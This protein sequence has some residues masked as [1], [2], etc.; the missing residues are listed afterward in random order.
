MTAPR[1]C[2]SALF[3]TRSPSARSGPCAS[4]RGPRTRSSSAASPSSTDTRAR[5]ATSACASTG[6]PCPRRRG[7]RRGG[8]STWISGSWHGASC[9]PHSTPRRGSAHRTRA[10]AGGHSPSWTAAISTPRSPRA[11]RRH[12]P[13]STRARVGRWEFDLGRVEAGREQEARSGGASVEL[14][15]PGKTWVHGRVVDTGTGQPTPV[16]L[17]FRSRE[18]RY[19]PP[20]GH[21]TEINDGWFQDYGADVKL[22]DTPFAYVD[23]TFQVEL[24]VGEVYVE[25]TKGFE[26][27]P[28]RR[29]L[30][31]E[32][33]QRE[34]EIG[35]A[36][37]TDLRSRRLGHG[38]H[39]RPLPV[40]VDRRPRGSGR[41]RQP[42]QPAGRAVGRSLHERGRPRA[43]CARVARR[44]DDR[45]GEHREP[46]APAR[47][48]GPRRR[49]GRTGLSHVGQRAR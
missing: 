16:R 22:M 32:A 27:A 28:V 1:P 23:G 18:G 48:P 35:I 19:V 49:Q 47:P 24:P 11:P 14:V 41:G 30:R 17:A 25:L 9:R 12:S 5:S 6:S 20:Y 13:S 15:E 21:T 45:A 4:R 42:R 8:G 26:Y 33:G 43:R 7:T 44:R 31:I 38:G 10:W 3:R 46:A 39:P 2:G 29:R 34:L 40:A 36:R 37:F